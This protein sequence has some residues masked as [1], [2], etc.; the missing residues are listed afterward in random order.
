MITHAPEFLARVITTHELLIH[1]YD[2]LLKNESSVRLHPGESRLKKVWQQKSGGKVILIA[3]FDCNGMIY[4]QDCLS[5]IRMNRD[6]Y[7]MVLNQL[8]IYIRRK[9]P[10]LVGCW[11]LHEDNAHQ[12]MTRLIFEYRERHNI[13]TMTYSQYSPNLS[14]LTSGCSRPSN[15]AYT[16]RNSLTMQKS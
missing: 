16:V 3:F 2:P 5:R 14:S 12:H 9:H 13:Q 1:H 7:I 15:L 10:E 8:H 4:Q 11:I 6:Y